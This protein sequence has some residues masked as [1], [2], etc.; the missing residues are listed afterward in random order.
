MTDMNQI[1]DQLNIEGKDL[2]KLPQMLNV[3]TI[4]TYI[5]SAWQVCAGIYTYFTIDKSYAL[6]QQLADGEIGDS[7]KFLKGIMNFSADIVRKQVENKTLIVILT[8]V[9][10][11]LTFYGA[12]QMRNL[13]SKGFTIYTIGE[14]ALPITTSILLGMGGFGATSL[15]F[16]VLF[17]VLYFTQRKHLV[18]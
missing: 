6:L 2:Q 4:L 7:P 5:A 9:C 1:K 12:M 8:V 17:V 15:F 18:N 13:K 14:L 16:P 11:I 10:G 3:L